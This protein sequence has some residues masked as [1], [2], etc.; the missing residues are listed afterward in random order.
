[1]ARL[2]VKFPDGSRVLQEPRGEDPL[3]YYLAN[4]DWSSGIAMEIL[5]LYE[6]HTAK[7]ATI[8]FWKDHLERLQS[9]PDA[10][11]LLMIQRFAVTLSPHFSRWKHLTTNWP[12]WLVERLGETALTQPFVGAGWQLVSAESPSFSLRR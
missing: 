6:E 11:L 5:P 8:R 12:E 7:V 2:D 4:G 1:M 9:I 10:D 3:V